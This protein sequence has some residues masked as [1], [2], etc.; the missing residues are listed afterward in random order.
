MRLK[1]VPRM[2]RLIGIA[3]N[4]WYSSL[5]G[6]L[7]TMSATIVAIKSTTEEFTLRMVNRLTGLRIPLV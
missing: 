6:L 7:A 1:D 3:S 2:F 5:S 4:V